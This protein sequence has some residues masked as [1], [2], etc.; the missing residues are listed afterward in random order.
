MPREIGEQAVQ[1]AQA[2]SQRRKPSR[3]LAEPA[4]LVE[5]TAT[6]ESV[7]EAEAAQAP[8]PQEPQN[9]AASAAAQGQTT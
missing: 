7:Q 3:S 8:V 4:R 1:A 9:V 2:L 5:P 6:A